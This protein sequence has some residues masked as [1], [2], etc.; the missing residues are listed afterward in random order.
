VSP[1]DE[2]PAAVRGAR[3]NETH[4]V[5]VCIDDRFESGKQLGDVLDFI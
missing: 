1:I 2:E 3:Q 5:A 4:G